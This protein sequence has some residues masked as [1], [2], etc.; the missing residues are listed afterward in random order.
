MN[1]I[2]DESRTSP[3]TSS[4]YSTSSCS[5]STSDLSVSS[6]TSP[7]DFDYSDTV[8]N[9]DCKHRVETNNHYKLLTSE[10]TDRIKREL[11]MFSW[12]AQQTIENYFVDN[13]V[14]N[15]IKLFLSNLCVNKI[16][17]CKSS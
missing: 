16:S 13:K 4:D 9:D 17:L 15:L 6:V 1:R 11:A 5:S 8:E 3:D 2:L 12:V 7:V 10:E 14:E